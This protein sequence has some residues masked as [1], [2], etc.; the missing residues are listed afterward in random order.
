MTLH[1]SAMFSGGTGA[2]S[3]R[4]S[5]S[6]P[7]GHVA[8]QSPQPMQRFSSQNDPITLG[9]DGIHLAALYTLVAADAGD[10]IVGGSERTRHLIRRILQCLERSEYATAVAAAATG[11]GRLL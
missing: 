9:R 1:I 11:C 7:L 10:R 2:S 5:W 6:A 3:R 8:T 4:T